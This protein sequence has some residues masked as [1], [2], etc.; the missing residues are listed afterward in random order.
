MRFK[1][2]VEKP[3]PQIPRNQTN[4]G[5]AIQIE[6][7]FHLHFPYQTPLLP[8]KTKTHPVSIPTFQ[9]SPLKP[10][11]IPHT[12]KHAAPSSHL[13]TPALWFSTF[14]LN[15]RIVFFIAS[16]TVLSLFSMPNSDRLP[17]SSSPSE[18]ALD[19]SPLLGY[20]LADN[21]FRSRRFIR[22]TPPPPLR[23]ASRLLR[24]A[25]GRRMM[26]REP[27]FRVRENAAEQLEE[28]QRDWAHSKPVIILDVLWNLAFVGIGFTVFGLSMKETPVVPLRLWIIGYVAQ[29]L[30]HIACVIV[31]YRKPPVERTL[32]AE[33]SAGWENG[34]DADSNSNSGSVSD[35]EEYGIEQRQV[36]EETS[37]VK[38]LETANTMFSFIWWIIGFY[39]VTVGGQ[40]LTHDAPQLYWLC[41]TLLAF[42][43]VFVMICVAVASLV[44]IAV[45]CCLPCI[46]TILYVVTDQEGATTD[47]IDRLPK[48][49]FRKIGDVDKVDGEIQESFR[50]KMTECNT[51]TP[52]ERVLSQE[53]AE[54]CICLSAYDDG[55]ELRELPCNHHFHCT[56]ID[57]WLH[58]NATCPLCKFNILKSVNQSGEEA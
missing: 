55:T 57:K 1:F 35:A 44:G 40:T 7:T 52:I 15:L 12:H 34:A 22:R 17:A 41:I 42:D 32:G 29:C 26:L 20:S 39:W 18:S 46:I 27:S 45:C 2:K 11:N 3:P 9:I 38:N 14:H 25:S 13:N 5:H 24:R 31:V 21:L 51:D 33:G 53:D 49:K 56:C 48:Y 30:M 43:I 6:G 4:T 8:I 10:T 16:P 36:E 50:G 58:I 47:E 54:C 23:G 28:R 19:T 37:V